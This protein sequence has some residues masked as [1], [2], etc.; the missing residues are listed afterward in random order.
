M[1]S[2][3]FILSALLFFSFSKLGFAQQNC[4][5]PQT[6]TDMNICSSLSYKEAD[7]KLNETYRKAIKMLENY[8]EE[9]RLEEF[10]NIQRAWIKYR[11]LNC[12]YA[13]DLYKGGS[14][15]PLIHATC[16][17]QLTEERTKR[18][19]ELFAEWN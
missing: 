1:L 3:V 2:K 13:S 15:V 19:P 11:D 6:Q 14:I 4:E 5:S 16:M 8:N 10:K 18:I 12:S 9:G 17:E 7:I